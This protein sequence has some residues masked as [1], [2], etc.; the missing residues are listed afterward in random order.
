MKKNFIILKKIKTKLKKFQTNFKQ[1]KK[2]QKKLKQALEMIPI[3]KILKYL[4]TKM[5]LQ[6]LM[7]LINLRKLY[8]TWV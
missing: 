4:E 5:E 3:L 7:R 1:K 8:V 2:F 6:F